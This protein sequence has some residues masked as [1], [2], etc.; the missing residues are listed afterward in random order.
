MS[1]PYD[2]RAEYRKRIQQRQT[3][4]FG[5]I[6]AVMAFLF[7]FGSLIWVGII[8][9][10]FD[11]EFSKKAEPVHIVPCPPNDIQARDLTTIT[12]RVYNSTSV[13]GQAGAVGQ[14]L[15]TLGVTVA[16]TS[17]WRGAPLPEATRIITGKNNIDAAYTLR[18]YFPGSTI[19]FDE[20]NTSDLLDIVIGKKFNGTNIGPSEED[21]TSALEPIK[22]CT[23]IN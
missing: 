2:P 14:D 4:I 8:P 5:S 18:A 13:S 16:E 10:P 15:T 11:R 7:V 23:S 22:D 1:T 6:S 3:V 20:T 19:H 9:A 21:L 17:N 12:A